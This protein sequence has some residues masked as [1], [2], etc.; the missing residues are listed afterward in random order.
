[1]NR[2][3]E[4]KR[5]SCIVFAATLWACG[6]SNNSVDPQPPNPP[7]TRA[8]E[9]ATLI[10]SVAEDTYHG[11]VVLYGS[12]DALVVW[13]AL[14]GYE[15]S[16][17]RVS[18]FDQSSGWSETP[19]VSGAGSWSYAPI[20]ASTSSDNA[21]LVWRGIKHSPRTFQQVYT[22]TYASSSG[23]SP[24]TQ[25]SLPGD[26]AEGQSAVESRGGAAIAVWEQGE[27][28]GYEEVYY[29]QFQSG[30]GW[31]A[32][33]A[34][35]NAYASVDSPTIVGGPAGNSIAFWFKDDFPNEDAFVAAPHNASSGWGAQSALDLLD[36]PVISHSIAS[37]N[38]DGA[39]IAFA[40]HNGQYVDVFAV[41]YFAAS[42]WES[43]QSIGGPN[44]RPAGL[45]ATNSGNSDSFIA[46]SRRTG[47]NTL[48]PFEVVVSRRVAGGVWGP[49]VVIDDQTGSATAVTIAADDNGGAIAAWLQH[50]GETNSV[51]AATFSP[52]SGWSVSQPLEQENGSPPN[53]H[54]AFAPKV[55]ANENGDAI[56]VWTQYDGAAHSIFAASFR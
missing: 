46:W 33:G 27:P 49:P 21:V 41:D 34:I 55:A 25:L 45:V 16:D 2:R 30:V 19:S 14:L 18:R 12:G 1:M 38:A 53:W 48:D 17:I 6:G 28:S 15:L 39:T 10:E 36:T 9:P 13:Q 22:A 32:S 40:Q 4:V 37:G 5:I 24:E 20:I 54:E 26:S 47:P 8:W 35:E 56:V 29:A 11:D 7:P 51:F 31:G 3:I 50:D 52:D 42:G 23:W 44:P 43:P